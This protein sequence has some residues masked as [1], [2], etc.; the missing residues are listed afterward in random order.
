MHKLNLHETTTETSNS[1]LHM[2]HISS[3]QPV[4]ETN[5]TTHNVSSFSNQLQKDS[6]ARSPKLFTLLS[7]VAIVAG[8]ATGYG[9]Y[10]LQAKTSIGGGSNK[11]I[12]Q[13]AEGT[14]EKGDVFG[15]EDE[16]T[17]KD[18]AEG[19]LEAGGLDGEGSHKLVRAGGESQTVYL[20]SSVTDLDKLV[21]MEVK[22]WGETFKGQTAGWLMDVGR[23]EVLNPQ[24]KAPAEE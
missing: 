24:G 19:Y 13:V 7:L 1:E 22:V 4:D 18:S 11:P 5:A 2:S 15:M 16:K 3:E 8:I 9:G 12:K 6:M 17:F 21:G 10:K 23:I 14:V 20:T